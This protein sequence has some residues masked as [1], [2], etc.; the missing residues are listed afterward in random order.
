MTRGDVLDDRQPEPGPSGRPRSGGVHAVEALEDPVQVALV[1]AD[2]LVGHS[3]LH[4]LT[5]GAYP[6]GDLGV[7][8]AVG[9]GV[10]DQVAQRDDELRLVAQHLQSRLPAGGQ[11]DV[12]VLG[13]NAAAVEGARDDLVDLDRF[14][15]LDRIVV[16]QPRQVDDLL[17]KAGEPTALLLHPPGEPAHGLRVV[18]RV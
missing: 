13:V 15:R 12:P 16:L 10:L 3:D 1:D 11:P 7:R 17:D 8:L 5:R 6:D 9:H 18:A 4:Q 2:A 14:R